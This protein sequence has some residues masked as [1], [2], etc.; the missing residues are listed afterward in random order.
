VS[1]PLGDCESV[2]YRLPIRIDCV[3]ELDWVEERLVLRDLGSEAGVQ[4]R[5]AG[6]MRDLRGTEVT[7]AAREIEFAAAGAWVRA[8]LE[9]R[10]ASDVA[11][12]AQRAIDGV[13]A[14]SSGGPELD[15]VERVARILT[16]VAR[17]A[18]C[19]R[20]ALAAAPPAESGRR[21]ESAAALVRWMQ[22]ILAAVSAIERALDVARKMARESS[23]APRFTSSA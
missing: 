21:D 22:A 14:A 13:M 5:F 9:E 15:D 17:G 7:T 19:L 23:V 6:E 1:R 2:H 12:V 4:V 3:V 18:R 10:T 16:A 11:D 20:A 8:V